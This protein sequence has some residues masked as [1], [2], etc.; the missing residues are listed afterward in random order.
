MIADLSGKMALVMG[1][2]QID[3]DLIEA[4]KVAVLR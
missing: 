2:A 4:N 1:G 3:F